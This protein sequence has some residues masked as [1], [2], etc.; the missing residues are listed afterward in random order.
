[1]DEL[2]L[3]IDNKK[4]DIPTTE[5]ARAYLRAQRVRFHL[6][7]PAEGA[8]PE[9]CKP[10]GKKNHMNTG[11][12]ANVCAGIS[13]GRIVMWEYLPKCWNGAA[14]ATLYRGAIIKALKK[15]RGTKGTYTVFEDNDPS[16]YKSSVAL[17]A[18]KE[19]HIDAFPMPPYSPDLNPLDFG[20][21]DEIE[22]RMVEGAPKTVE[23]VA[24]YKKRMR[25]TALRLPAA[26]VT[27][28]VRKIPDRM[29]SVIAAKGHNIKDD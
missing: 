13:G 17:A 6:R 27:K 1:M 7:T 18:K 10:G 5:R 12:A 29:R 19:L 26:L 24:Q 2:D 23:T 20:I 4:F 22:S 15:A 8:Q 11:A 14:A 25:L 21:W 9:M 28:T 16:G 3:I